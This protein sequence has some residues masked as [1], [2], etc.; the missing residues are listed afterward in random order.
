RNQHAGFGIIEFD[1]CH[2]EIVSHPVL[3]RY[4]SRRSD[5]PCSLVATHSRFDKIVAMS[6]RTVSLAAGK[7]TAIRAPSGPTAPRSL[8]ESHQ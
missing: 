7:K 5:Q 6:S 4:S 1:T 3:I 2:R 8:T